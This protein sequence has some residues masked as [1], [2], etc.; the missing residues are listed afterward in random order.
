MDRSLF[1]I[2]AFI[3]SMFSL[4]IFF[5]IFDGVAFGL[6]KSITQS[7]ASKQA[8]LLEVTGAIGPATQDYILR[9]LEQAEAAKDKTLLLIIRLDTP[10]GLETAMRGIDR[11]I[12][13]SKIP[14]VVFVAPSGARAASAGTFILYASNIAAMAPGT[15]VGAASP[16]NI[17]GGDSGDNVGFFSEQKEKNEKPAKNDN[18]GKNDKSDKNE[19]NEQRDANQNSTQKQST[20]ERKA[21]QDSIAYIKSLAELRG[22]NVNWAMEAVRS[23]V[24]LSSEEAYQLK[25]IDLIAKDIPDLLHKINGWSK[26]LP[27]DIQSLDTEDLKVIPFEPDWRFQFLSVITDPTIAYILLLI[28]IYGLFFEFSN[29]GF[30]LPGVAGAI[31][32]LLA[33]Y[34]FQ[35]LPINYAG[36]GLLIL[37]IAC[38][39]AEVYISSFGALGIGGLIAFVAGSI[40][41]LDT[42]AQG[43][44]IAWQMILAMTMLTGG[45]FLIIM[46][47]AFRSLR[48]KVVT[49]HEALL[50]SQ[51]QVLEYGHH[52]NHWMVRIYG[53]I[54]QAHCNVPLQVGQIVRVVKVNEL[55]LEVEPLDRF[56]GTKE[57]RKEDTK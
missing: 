50:G 4:L 55:H 29:P 41:L 16:V 8:L 40:L 36:F 25:V 22:R 45:F 19:K 35:L 24:S 51:A 38:M 13:A 27:A 17:A 7:N 9:G 26:N 34:A 21:M 12:L 49:G 39:I 43:F 57:N 48:R 33:L 31:G 37:G 30:I 3:L 15:N 53:E 28:G 47:L 14:V 6:D 23:A 11:G 10:G 20:H 18:Q 52:N 56:E 46:N 54:W 42:G 32:L 1:K 2:P 5:I 44:N